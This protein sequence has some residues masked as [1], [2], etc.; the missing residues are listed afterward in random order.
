LGVGLD[1]A[2]AGGNVLV[3]GED[4]EFAEEGPH[5]LRLRG[6]QWRTRVH[7]VSSP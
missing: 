7:L 3:V 6:P 5:R 2:P 4:D 1:L